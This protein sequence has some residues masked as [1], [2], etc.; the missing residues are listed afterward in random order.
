MPRE[1]GYDNIS[2]M[3]FYKKTL[4]RNDRTTD[5]KLNLSLFFLISLLH[6]IITGFLPINLLFFSIYLFSLTSRT[7]SIAI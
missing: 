7:Y 3:Q 1:P 5:V 2:G 4:L 6:P